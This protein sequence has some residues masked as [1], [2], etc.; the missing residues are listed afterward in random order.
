MRKLNV[1]IIGISGFGKE[2]LNTVKKLEE[3]GRCH[4]KAICDIPSPT[5]QKDIDELMLKGVSFYENYLELL[6]TEKEL[7]IVSISTPIHL[8]KK[9]SIDAMRAG[10]HVFAEKPPAATIQD[11]DEMIKVS[12]ELQKVCTVN[13]VLTSA[14]AFNKLKDIVKDGQLGR[15]KNIV[16][17]GLWQRSSEYFTRSS[18]S[19]K[20]KV[21]NEYVLDGAMNNPLA[22]LLNNM[23]RIAVLQETNAEDLS[24]DREL[25]KDVTAELYHANK[26]EG[27]DTVCLRANMR[28]GIELNYYATLCNS[29]SEVPYIRVE[30]EFGTAVWN[31][32]NELIVNIE[33][34]EIAYKYERQDLM[35]KMYDNMFSAVVE[36]DIELYSSIED[37]RNFTLIV[38]GAFCSVKEVNSIPDKDI[39][40]KIQDKDVITCITN[41]N[42]IIEEASSEKLLFSELGIEWAVKTE[43]FKVDN[44]TYFK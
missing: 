37:A 34:K 19:G 4:L 36:K 6:S 27:D 14:E 40:I 22:H 23:I 44:F 9:M 28:N 1:A 32:R 26:I 20:L 24:K 29:T 5:N 43:P 38:N 13:F 2:H 8:H 10:F 7:D 41:I 17:V 18:W 16:G 12:N 39:Y 31:Y 11:V 15:I 33:G 30:G 42:K 3:A 21:G 35:W 25:I